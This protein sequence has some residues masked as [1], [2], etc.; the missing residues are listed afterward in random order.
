MKCMTSGRQSL[1]RC[2][3]PGYR[4][5]VLG[6]LCG[7]LSACSGGNS[8]GTSTTI[9]GNDPDP[10]S[11]LVQRAQENETGT[12]SVL[13]DLDTGNNISVASTPDRQSQFLARMEAAIQRT[14]CP[15]I[16]ARGSS[17]RSPTSAAVVGV[18][19]NACELEALRTLPE[20]QSIVEEI[21]LSHQLSAI[22]QAVIDSYNGVQAWPATVDG[23]AVNFSGAGRLVAVLDT[24][25]EA[26]HPALGNRVL[27][28]SCFSTRLAPAPSA[29]QMGFC[30]NLLSQDTTSATAGQACTQ[31]LPPGSPAAN[32][33]ACGHGTAMAGAAAMGSVINQTEGG[34]AKAASIWPIQVFR[35][36]NGSVT[37][38]GTDILMAL[39]WVAT[40]AERRRQNNLPPIVSVNMSL[41]GG[42]YAQACDNEPGMRPFV[43][44]INRLKNAQVLTMVATGNDGL[45][46]SIAFPA[47]ISPAFR[48]AASTLGA[49]SVAA[50]S[51]VSNLVDIFAIGG[52]YN[53][54]IPGGTWDANLRG[55]SPAT[56]LVSGAVAALSTAAPNATAA[57]I[58]Q[59]LTTGSNLTVTGFD[60]TKPGLHIT[61][62]TR[63][64][65]GLPPEAPVNPI[66]PPTPAPTPP[67]P[68]ITST[69]QICFQRGSDLGARTDCYVTGVSLSI[70]SAY[71]SAITTNSQ[72]IATV[73]PKA[74]LNNTSVNPATT[75]CVSVMPNQIRAW[76]DL[77]MTLYASYR[78]QS[79]AASQAVCLSA[80]AAR[81][82][83]Q[84]CLGATG[85][86]SHV[87]GQFPGTAQY[88]Y[89]PSTEYAAIAYAQTNLTGTSRP[90]TTTQAAGQLVSLQGINLASMRV[91]DKN[92]TAVCLY[93]EPN[94]TGTSVCYPTSTS[95]VGQNL[96]YGLSQNVK[97]VLMIG[98]A[99]RLSLCSSYSPSISG[100]HCTV[101]T[102]SIANMSGRN[103]GYKTRSF[104]LLKQ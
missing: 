4:L 44:V 86:L 62:A 21:T 27:P 75:P 98:G 3:Q 66:V 83:K 41:G 26:N 52:P 48:V 99:G 30:P 12:V 20:I 18:V 87:A 28:G 33:G 71:Y 73:C 93:T 25:S 72:G 47:C 42:A 68:I 63:T 7:L 74:T 37:A 6:L 81:L 1:Q 23:Q 101:T 92:E 43:N 60:V 19:L 76:G 2:L 14:G 94:F 77:F 97:S 36:V 80:D 29:N 24:G 67:A 45:R 91:F 13:I 79:L 51:N 61:S 8:G 9:S 50:F 16:S 35:L 89:L 46:G 69:G 10:I 11:L 85:S 15:A 88:L 65:L 78:V 54:P 55:T 82:G 96:A 102:S 32:V 34:I 39:D 100:P 17:V 5:L 57:Q 59:A 64:L 95:K 49:Q 56:A 22:D 31:V 70:F 103:I 90:I 40:E 58:Q 38:G 84:L 53:L 104:I